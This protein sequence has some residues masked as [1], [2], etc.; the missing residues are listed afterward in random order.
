MQI[1]KIIWITSDYRYDKNTQIIMAKY[2]Q[3]QTKTDPL[4]NAYLAHE[5]QANTI[6]MWA[7]PEARDSHRLIMHA[8]S[9]NEIQANNLGMGY[10][11]DEH[12]QTIM[13]H[14]MHTDLFNHACIFGRWGSSK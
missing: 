13:K 14:E 4:S 12:T 6:S 1:K 7:Y 10:V 2:L 9:E 3:H 11:Y 5:V 8:Y